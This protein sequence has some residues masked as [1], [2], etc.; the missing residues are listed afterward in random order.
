MKALI[1]AGGF[2]KRLRPYTQE[3]PKPLIMVADYPII[4]WQ[5]KWL[6]KYDIDEIILAVGYLKE[7]I[8]NEIGSG[9]KFGINVTY[10]VEEEPLGTG[11][12]IKN[13]ES[14][15]RKEE[16][17]FVLNGDTITNLDPTKLVDKIEEQN[18]IGA[19]ALVPLKSPYGIIN[20]ERE[21]GKIL[22]FVEKPYIKDYWI[23][24]GVYCLKPS[25]FDYL[26]DKGNVEKIGFPDLAKKGKLVGVPFGDVFWKAIDTHKDVEEAERLLK[27]ENF[28]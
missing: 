22:E 24:A 11:G 19:L 7:K 8:I 18:A 14:V 16:I 4:V 1:L 23:N 25:V 3:R 13:A 26:P 2:G 15:L 27:S 28:S 17:F 20:F 21:T 10:V 6:K 5:I 12:A 9:R